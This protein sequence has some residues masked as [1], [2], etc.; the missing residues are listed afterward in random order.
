MATVIIIVVVILSAF[1]PAVLPACLQERHGGSGER[2]GEGEE[3]AVG[4]GSEG[5]VVLEE[6]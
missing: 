2:R 1:L 6:E 3:D 5:K 4:P